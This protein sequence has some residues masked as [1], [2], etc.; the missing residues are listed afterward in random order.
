MA[1]SAGTRLGPY[2]IVGPLGAGGMGEIYRARDTRLDRTVAVK[3][4]PAEVSRD[5]ARR[6]R[7]ER[8]AK[9]IAALTHPNICTIYDVGDHEGIV[10]LVMELLD[11]ETLAARLARGPLSISDALAIATQI[12][13]GLDGAHRVGIVHRD[14]KPANVML[15]RAGASGERSAKAKLLDFGLA[16]F[17]TAAVPEGDAQTATAPLTMRGEVVGTLPYMAPEQL[18][19]KPIDPRTDVF[20]FG[21]ML[22]EMITGQRAFAGTS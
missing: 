17:S 4:L 16:T 8:E 2:Q 19:G 12:A 11:G 13:D 10:F 14:L 5:T 21:A 20:A 15:T 3:V 1:L 7:F 9:A 22:H 6:R 18:E